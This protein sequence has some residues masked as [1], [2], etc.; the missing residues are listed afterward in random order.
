MRIKRWASLAVAAGTLAG[1]SALPMTTAQAAP[2]TV[3]VQVGGDDGVSGVAFEGMRFLAPDNMSVHKGDTITFNF[4]GFHTATLLPDG[5]SPDEWSAEHTAPLSGD[6]SLVVPDSDDGAG[7]F[8]FGHNAAFPS[9]PTCGAATAP[10]PYDGKAVVNSG[11]PFSANSF[12]VTIN[13]QPGAVIWV[14]CLIHP[15]MSM[16]LQVVDD[17]TVTTTQADIDSYKT[18]TLAQDHEAAAAL[19][20]RLQKPTKHKTA[21]GKTV[22]DAFAGFDGDGWGLD[23]MFPSRLP[24]N[25]GDTVRWHF[26]QLMG[27]IHTVTFPKKQAV[28]LSSQFGTPMC[29]ADP[30]DTPPD[31]APPAFCS[32]GPQNLELHIPAAALLPG[33]DHKYAGTASGLHSSGVEGAGALT[34]AVYDLKFTHKSHRKGFRYACIVHGGMMSG[35]VVVS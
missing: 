13:D 10:C 23:A 32:S 11:A 7:V 15:G 8:E 29:E 9:D 30:A 33:G 22:W 20:P 6:Y 35:T 25:K 5:E 34:T 4:A 28:A 18:A 26:T 3:N 12:S 19:I 24:I 31:A 14:V 16:R 27:N 17:A 2:V 21:S 1:V